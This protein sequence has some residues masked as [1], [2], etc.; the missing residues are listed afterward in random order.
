MN[1]HLVR[2]TCWPHSHVS[3][4]GLT[5]KQEE[6]LA[7]QIPKMQAV[8]P[9]CTQLENGNQ[10]IVITEGRTLVHPTK[11]YTCRHGHLTGIAAFKS[12]ML[13]V[14]YGPGDNFVNIEGTA[15]E[16]PELIDSKQIACNHMITGK[17]E[18]RCVCKLKPVDDSPLV[19]PEGTNFKTKRRLGDIWDKNGME[20]VRPGT[21]DRDG[22]FD[23]SKTDRANRARLK[24]MRKD[25][26]NTSEQRQ[27]GQR[28]DHATDTDY[29]HKSKTQLPGDAW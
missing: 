20:P 24:V 1:K 15:E 13:N 10:P 17:T 22:N 8:C 14:T 2:V 19:Y 6:R 25:R 5:L 18:R 3:D 26:R 28:I 7:R 12:G 29:G 23:E 21:Y 27:P 16:L 9:K 4:L 11:Y